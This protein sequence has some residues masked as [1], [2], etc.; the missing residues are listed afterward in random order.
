MDGPTMGNKRLIERIKKELGAEQLPISEIHARLS[1]EL[2][3][4]PEP[5]G[6]SKIMMGRFEMVSIG[7]PKKKKNEW[8]NK[9]D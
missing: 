4:Y 6:L 8:R 7:S 5:N 3:Y 9:I 1:K 2:V